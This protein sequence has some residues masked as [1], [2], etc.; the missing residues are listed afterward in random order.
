MPPARP[1][2]ALLALFWLLT[3]SLRAQPT[4]PAQTVSGTF[5]VFWGDPP[6]PHEPPVTLF[7]LLGDDGSMTPLQAAESAL[8]RFGGPLALNQRRVLLSGVPTPAALLRGPGTAGMRAPLQ[9]SAV[10]GVQDAPRAAAAAPAAPESKPFISILCKFADSADSVPAPPAHFEALMG[11]AYPGVNHYWTEVSE[12]RVNLNGSRVVGWYTLPQPRSYYVGSG[13]QSADLGKLASDCTAAAD[14]VVHFPDYFGINLQFNQRL[15]CCSWGGGRIMTLDGVTRRY[16]MT[17]EAS[18][19]AF[20]LGTWVHEVGHALGLPHSGGPYGRVYDSRWDVMSSS[21]W[22]RPPGQS[23]GFGTH[24]VT[25]HKDLLGWVPGARK[26]VAAAPLSTLTLERT[27]LPSAAHYQM[28]EIPIPGAPGE[29]FTVEARRGGG[30]DSPLPEGVVIHRV[31]RARAEPAQVVDADGNGNP[32]DAGATWSPGEVFL[33]MASGIRVRVDAAVGASAFQVTIQNGAATALVVE[34][35]PQPAPVSAGAA[36]SFADSAR[37]RV[38]GAAAATLAWSASTRSRRIELLTREGRGSGVVR[39]R[40]RPAGLG[41][42]VYVDTITVAAAGA[43]NTPQRIVDTLRVLE[44]PALALGLSAA[45]RAAVAVADGF[46]G[47]DSVQVRPS[48]PGA[49]TL[50][51]SASKRAAWI[52]FAEPTPTGGLRSTTT[53]PAGTGPGPLRWIRSPWRLAPGV[54]VDTIRVTAAGGLTTELVD[55][56]RVREPASVALQRGAPTPTL[57]EGSAGAADSFY[58]ALGGAGAEEAEWFAF[59]PRRRF[60]RPVTGTSVGSG[61]VRFTRSPGT[62][63]AGT[64]VDTILVT[65]RQEGRSVAFVDTLVVAP[66]PPALRLATPARSDSVV[67]GF[68]RSADSVLVEVLGPGAAQKTWRAQARS[69]RSVLS[70]RDAFTPA[71]QGTGSAWLRWHR[72]TAGLGPGLYVDTIAVAL[73]GDSSVAPVLLVDSLRVLVPPHL[74][75]ASAGRAGAALLGGAPQTDSVAVRL[76]GFGAASVAWQAR[77]RAGWLRLAA[78]AGVGSG[79]L[80]WT[81]SPAGL[82]AG[83]YVDSIVVSPFA[84]AGGLQLV[85]TLYVLAAAPGAEAAI[86]ELLGAA[87]LLAGERRLLDQQGNRDGVYNL[88]DLLA[89]L[90]RNQAA[91]AP[92]LMERLLQADAAQ[93]PRAQPARPPGAPSE[94]ERT[95]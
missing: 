20:A 4:A 89:L 17:W 86:D 34:S 53:P 9:V 62:L 58:V 74:S 3:P 56:L 54:Y 78:E 46:G 35:R 11:A 52:S 63:G 19:A 60:L 10:L 90:D 32:N 72:N 47:A 45:S 5:Q 95:P 38:S 49:A 23:V 14:S 29:F 71:G 65:L 51:W 79:M 73:P 92:E 48:G 18:W 1:L 15:D 16:A 88:G 30:Y 83:T 27:A 22:F 64:V 50:A 85:D 26:F 36:V 28:A 77:S 57:P 70:S 40:T 8:E 55:T 33:D 44:P 43:L 80:R 25:Y 39:W 94:P 67:L 87:R 24:T 61:W 7:V 81:R 59:S 12:G 93:P 31:F 91:L 84:A 68:A 6:T 82:A 2:A 75:G 41:A 42:G 69:S 13:S 37:L 21:S 66:S 76:Q